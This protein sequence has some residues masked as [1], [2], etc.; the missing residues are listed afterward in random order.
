M[1]NKR[2]QFL[3]YFFF[4]NLLTVLIILF[5]R[6]ENQVQKGKM[7]CLRVYSQ[8]AV[9]LSWN[10]GWEFKVFVFFMWLLV[11]WCLD[12][13]SI[14]TGVFF[15]LG[16]GSWWLGWGCCWGQ[17]LGIRGFILGVV[18]WRR[19]V[20]CQYWV[21]SVQFIQFLLQIFLGEMGWGGY[22]D[23]FSGF[24]RLRQLRLVGGLSSSF[25]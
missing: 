24:L 21:C 2:E 8:E 18:W 10:F 15:F 11:F 7:I 1:F 22:V 25:R 13:R 12:E 4:I 19:G 23:L 16:Q 5:C 17:E 14:L 9:V 20:I 6:G 3:F